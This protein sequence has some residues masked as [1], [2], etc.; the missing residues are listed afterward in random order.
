MA[1]VSKLQKHT[2]NLFAGDFAR[3]GDL[4]PEAD[5]SEVLRKILRDFIA[6]MENGAEKNVPEVEV[7][8]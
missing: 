8:L 5:R 1:K 6:K 2:V 4:F 7:E 3:L